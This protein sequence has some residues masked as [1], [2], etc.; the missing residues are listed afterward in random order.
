MKVYIKTE[1]NA[2][3]TAFV[4]TQFNDVNQKTFQNIQERNQERQYMKESVISKSE[5][6][7]RNQVVG[8]VQPDYRRMRLSFIFESKYRA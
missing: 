8:M 2:E 5:E 3:N 7:R 1:R 6:K 4:F